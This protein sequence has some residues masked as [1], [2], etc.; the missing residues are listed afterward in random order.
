MN[1]VEWWNYC[2]LFPC[3]FDQLLHPMRPN[4]NGSLQSGMG[5]WKRQIWKK[6]KICLSLIRRTEFYTNSIKLFFQHSQCI[7]GNDGCV[8]SVHGV[9]YCTE[10]SKFFFNPFFYYPSLSFVQFVP[11]KRS[12]LGHM[13]HVLFL[14]NL[15]G[16]HG[17]PDSES[18]WVLKSAEQFCLNEIQ[19]TS[20]KWHVNSG[21]ID[22]FPQDSCSANL[23]SIIFQC[24]TAESRCWSQHVFFMQ[25]FFP[26]ACLCCHFITCAR[27]DTL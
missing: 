18:C 9:W 3:R 19:V 1:L 4:N 2:L 16:S 13:S 12:L 23:W 10:V 20:Q 25:Y 11:A 5:R 24:L 7:M 14:W 6:T 17:D 8:Q 26:P 22:W 21:C 27:C 15:N